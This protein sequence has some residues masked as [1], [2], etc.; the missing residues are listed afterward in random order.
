MNAPSLG[1][2]IVI[3]MTYYGVWTFIIVCK[4]RSFIEPQ[5]VASPLSVNV[6]GTRA[7]FILILFIFLSIARMCRDSSWDLCALFFLPPSE[8]R[9]TRKGHFV[10]GSNL[11]NDDIY[12]G[13]EINLL[14]SIKRRP[15][16]ASAALTRSLAYNME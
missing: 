13:F 4:I 2:I 10:G 6:L 3:N 7:Y 14:N 15:E 11:A 5:K 1:T 8:K 16:C 9:Y 12:N